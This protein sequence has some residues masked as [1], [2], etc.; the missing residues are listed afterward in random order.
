MLN[1]YCGR[2]SIDKEK[3]IFEQIGKVAKPCLVIV[4]D[5]YTLEG[6]KQALNFLDTSCLLDVEIV[7]TS[8]L[9]SRIL[10]KTGGGRVELLDKYGRHM[11]LV[12]IMNRLRDEL[13]VFAVSALKP[14]FLELANNLISQLK[15]YDIEPALL[16]ELANGLEADSLLA[17]KLRDFYKI[18]ST[19]EEEISGKFTDSEDL[20]ELYLSKIK[21]WNDLD[22]KDIW[23][24]G[25]DSFA[26]KALRIM[27]NLMDKADNMNVFLTYDDSR[28]DRDLFTLTGIVRNSF[29]E[30]A[31][32]RNI[33]WK[34]NKV[35]NASY[36]GKHCK[37]IG[38]LEQELYNI[39]IQPN[40][41]SDGVKILK[42]ANIY[43]EAE[44]AASYVMHLV[45]DKG[46]RFRDIV[47]ICNDQQIRAS[48]IKRVFEEWGIRVFDD[49][50]R[51]L[52][53][54]PVAILVA[55]M[56][57]T[58]SS[59]YT[60]DNLFKALK[61]GLFDVS[62]DDIEDLENYGIKYRIRGTM[63]KKDFEKGEAEYKSDLERIRQV[64]RDVMAP[65][66]ILERMC[67][68]A[69]TTEEFVRA[70][71]EFLTV[72]MNLAEKIARI[73]ERQ[74]DLGLLDMA[75]ETAQ[76]WNGV[77][78]LFEQIH[79]LQEGE[80]FEL[81]NFI[82]LLAAG[83]SQLEVGVIPQSSDE[84]LM[85]TM[86]RTRVGSTRATLVLGA[87]EGLIPQDATNQGIF[88]DDEL[89]LL[90]G[91]GKDLCKIEDVRVMEE[92]LAIYRNFSKPSEFLWIS[93]STSD[94]EGK[95]LRP[96]EIIDSILR[97]FPELPVESDI[98]TRGDEL[99]FI[100]GTTNTIRHLSEALGQARKGEKISGIWKDVITWLE[101]N[102]AEKLDKIKESLAFDND[103]PMLP[104]NIVN[105]LYRKE[106]DA[107]FSISPSRLEKFSR[108]PFAHFVNY[109]LKPAER[110]SFEAA[111]REIGDVYHECLMKITEKLTAENRWESVT[112][113]QCKALI[114][115]MLESSLNEYREGVFG[116]TGED[117][118]KAQR[119][120]DTIFQ[121][122]WTLIQQ[123]NA[124]D[125]VTSKF[126]TRFGR[127][128]DLNPIEVK[129]GDDTVYIEG[130]IDR[131]DFLKDDLVKIIDYKTGHE[132]FSID[133][134]RAGYRLQ[135][136]L[137]LKA[138]QEQVRQP[139]G[140]FY[141]L[142]AE[143]NIDA[144]KYNTEEL[145]EK[146]AGEIKRK[147]KLDGIM[148]DKA[149]VING[150]AGDFEGYSDIVALRKTKDGQISGSALISEEDFELLQKSVDEKIS[151][152]CRDLV[153][154]R[155][156][157]NPKK[158][159]K[160]SPCVYC[161]YKGICR[162]DTDFRGCNYDMI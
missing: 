82:E 41:E 121:V 138:A 148:V 122:C 55:S 129:L 154:G 104:R 17:G 95:E 34:I 69:E 97:I 48:A 150:I 127:R 2:E 132:H 7:S 77:A 58:V 40:S 78:G 18:Y 91:K 46:L 83:M 85:G 15:Q 99:E 145:A 11:L 74:E 6:E 10:A 12:S 134:A 80:K 71:Y 133:E 5:Q 125:I 14:D 45:R 124:G 159:S 146:I 94:E 9:G 65:F 162:F 19:Y 92:K 119:I 51:T 155:I 81:A 84:I 161:E 147:F 67:R 110:R 117:R 87:N 30:L 136:M 90:S 88:A 23:V 120:K 39:N 126:E 153:L 144:T 112:K 111:A 52:M 75:E 43:S 152:L 141:F 68:E 22:G 123:V 76:V 143:Q 89:A 54:H 73:I 106:N 62:Q 37:G 1:I 102:R 130:I 151:E 160:T 38:T 158:T 114:D 70:Y 61:T 36:A 113:E 28:G 149:S 27:G 135:L 24:Y 93:Y 118:Y 101:N 44:S 42:A 72:N 98:I 29:I 128:G 108:C 57:E 64:R 66:E 4:P 116:Y 26:P 50:K 103:P 157:I 32:E 105:S 63:W 20:I 142:I 59:K 56:L 33:E 49:K 8:R 35:D 3:Y 140:V 100:C 139:A 115:E 47:V 109:G 96:S 13:E 16:S 60:K 79:Q 86:Q 131:V 31:K 53:N 107:D 21:D 137:Y 156:A 25:F